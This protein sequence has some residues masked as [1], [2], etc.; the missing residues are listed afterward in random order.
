MGLCSLTTENKKENAK[1]KVWFV[2][3]V[4]QPSEVGMM[5][6]IG[7]DALYSFMR[8]TWIG[9]SSASCH[10][11]N[12]NTTCMMSPTSMS[13]FKESLMKKGKLHVKVCQVNRT[14]LVHTL[15]PMKFCP[16]AGA[17]MFSLTYKLLQGNMI[18]S[19]HHK[20][21][22]VNTTCGDIILDY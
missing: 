16:K 11:T 17:N 8:N 19:D 1:K 6:T 18:S 20:N 3:D 10:I 13:C 4:K 9:D 7:G 2:E 15:W 21:I 14:Q 22:V 12:D 5:C